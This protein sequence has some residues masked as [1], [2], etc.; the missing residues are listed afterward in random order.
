MGEGQIDSDAERLRV[1]MA[2]P[3]DIK[4]RI[5]NNSG[6]GSSYEQVFSRINFF[7]DCFTGLFEHIKRSIGGWREI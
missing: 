5:L 2:F 7:S 1:S 3:V 6:G 4:N